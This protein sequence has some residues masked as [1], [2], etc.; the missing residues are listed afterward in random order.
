MKSASRLRIEMLS[1]FSLSALAV[2]AGLWAIYRFGPRPE[3]AITRQS[4][5]SQPVSTPAPNQESASQAL[6]SDLFSA[7]FKAST[8]QVASGRAVEPPAKYVESLEAIYRGRGYR[9]F[10]PASVGGRDR[11]SLEKS[12]SQMLNQMRLNQMRLNQLRG[13]IYWLTEAAGIST[14][15]AWGEDADPTTEVANTKSSN[16]QKQMYLTTVAPAEDGGSQWTTYRYLAEASRLQALNNQL[17]SDGDWPGQDP[18]GIPRPSGL[19]RLISVGQP[20]NQEGGQQSE[21]EA[22]RSSM[23]VVYQSQQRAE[24]LA[25]WYAKEMPLAGWSLSPQVGQSKEKKQGAL[26]FIKDHRS[27]LVWIKSGAG[28]DQTTVVISAR[29]L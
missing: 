23:M 8:S 15:A 18:L 4:A 9:R 27:C 24:P 2:V 10:E 21:A 29:A 14:I 16:I 5:A 26:Y 22:D 12:R 1:G 13:K 20:S 19:R 7:L 11:Q 28:S 17:Q 3:K 25:E 6:G